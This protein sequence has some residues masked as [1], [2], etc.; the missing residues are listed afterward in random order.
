[1]FGKFRKKKSPDEPDQSV[2][3]PRIKPRAFTAALGQMGIPRDQMPYTEPLA[4]DLL[5]AYAFDMPGL[6]MMASAAAIAKLGVPPDDVRRTALAN[7]K[8]QLPEVGV[9]DLGPVRRVVTGEN[10]EACI[11]LAPT[12]W[13]EV[14]EQVEGDVVALA[15]SRD[16]LLFCGSDS[17]EG[18]E[19]LRVL[20]PELNKAQGNHGLS[21]TLIVWRDG[22]WA[23]YEG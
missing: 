19:A 22:Q 9:Q 7:L 18:V 4:A 21:E 6:F 8:R 12:F 3:V 15:A 11:L 23:E 13:D 16:D 2:L 1:M 14:A 17:E 5:V 10:L 20:A